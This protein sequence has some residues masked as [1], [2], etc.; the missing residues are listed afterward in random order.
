MLLLLLLSCVQL[1]FDP[2]DC[3]PQ[4]PLFMGFPRQEFWSGMPLP[5]P[6]ELSD[7]GT[8]SMSPATAVCL[9]AQTVKSLPKTRETQVQSLGREA[10]LEKEMATHS[11]VLAWRIPWMEEPGGLQSMGSQRVGLFLQ[12]VGHDWANSLSWQADS[13]ALSHQRSSLLTIC[14]Q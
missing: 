13:L 1:F 8:E 9:V 2:M 14:P 4:A 5:S 6:G 12:R 3:S 10:P 11:R 7:P